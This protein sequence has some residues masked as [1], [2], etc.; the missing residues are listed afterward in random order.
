MNS[1]NLKTT[2]QSLLAASVLLLATV[3]LS[4]CATPSTYQAMTPTTVVVT[5]KQS[6]SVVVNVTGGQKTSSAGKSQ[7]SNEAFKQAI[8]DSIKKSQVFSSVTDS[9]GDYQLTASI[10]GMD[11]PSF[12]LSFTVKMEAGWTLKRVDS[13]AVVWQEAIKSQHTAT[14][15]DAFA[16]VARLRMANEG[17]AR[18]NIS[19]ALEKISKLKL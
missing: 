4:G 3:G 11:Q 10:I 19:Q 15:S 2:R 7:I 16:G 5:E 1:R 14:T 17:A 13:G 12:G 9:T 18:N 6:G 8:V